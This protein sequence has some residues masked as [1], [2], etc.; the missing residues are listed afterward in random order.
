[1]TTSAPGWYDDPWNPTSIRYWDG[2]AWTGHVQPR[3]GAEASAG[4]P[5]EPPASAAPTVPATPTEPVTP[6]VPAAPGAW[7]TVWIWLIVLLPVVP[8]L[9]LPFIPWRSFLEMSMATTRTANPLMPGM[10]GSGFWPLY[11]IT[12][13]LSYVIYGLCVFFAYRD[14]RQLAQR[15]IVKPFHWAWAFLN[16]VYPIGRSVVVKRRTGA[17]MAPFWAT[18]GVLALS[19]VVSIL[20]AGIAFGAV[21]DMMREISQTRLR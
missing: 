10:M 19:L 13:L 3:P 7:N 4:T 5:V 18:M 20:V 16:V 8:I 14:Y 12:S 2:A 1:M 15:G 11:L 17:G 6:T 9:L 21:F